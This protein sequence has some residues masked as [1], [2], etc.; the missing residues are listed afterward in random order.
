MIKK[1]KV[2]LKKIKKLYLYIKKLYQITIYKVT[3][4]IFFIY[5]SKFCNFNY[6][7]NYNE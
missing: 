1:I 3:D 4:Y 2:T 5:I 7:N 6:L